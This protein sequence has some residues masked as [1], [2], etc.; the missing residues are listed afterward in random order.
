MQIPSIGAE[1][2][3]NSMRTQIAQ[4]GSSNPLQ[5]Q[6][7]EAQTGAKLEALEGDGSA[8]KGANLDVSA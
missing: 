6:Q 5:V 8:G 7:I 1:A 4:E 2:L 3:L